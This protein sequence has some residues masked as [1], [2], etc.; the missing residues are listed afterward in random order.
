MD[1]LRAEGLRDRRRQPRRWGSGGGRLEPPT[2]RET[3]LDQPAETVSV[4]YRVPAESETLFF[5]RHTTLP[6]ELAGASQHKGAMAPQRIDDTEDA[7]SRFSKGSSGLPAVP[8]LEPL[9]SE[10]VFDKISASFFVRT[11]LDLAPRDLAPACFAIVVDGARFSF[12][13]FSGGPAA[14]DRSLFTVAGVSLRTD[15]AA[16]AGFPTRERSWT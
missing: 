4:E 14:R 1:E 8:E 12:E 10:A 15:T 9:P 6:T 2:R 13:G 7:S 3:D 16:C 5:V 11:P